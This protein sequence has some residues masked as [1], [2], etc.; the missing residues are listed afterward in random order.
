MKK[1]L[2]LLLALSPFITPA[3]INMGII[4]GEQEFIRRST[5]SCIIV[6]RQDYVMKDTTGGKNQVFGLNGNTYFGR[7]YTLAVLVDTVII[8]DPALFTPWIGDTSY[9][10]YHNMGLIPMLTNLSYRPLYQSQFVTF[11]GVK[12][13]MGAANDSILRKN[14]LTA[15][16][17][18]AFTIKP[19]KSI[20]N[21]SDTSGWL[22]LVYLNENA[23]C[24]TCPFVYNIYKA[25]PQLSQNGKLPKTVQKKNLIGGL[26]F[27]PKYSAAHIE[28]LIAGVLRE[29]LVSWNIKN[30][31]L[32]QNNAGNGGGSV[33]TPV[34]P[35][36]AS[37][38]GEG[39]GEG[40]RPKR[41][42]DKEQ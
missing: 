9:T 20:P 27:I 40:G 22:M 11:T 16:R 21:N 25:R 38:S 4:S 42:K 28:I 8:F 39:S 24:D 37:D 36:D 3:Q 17:N 30:I 5:D 1:I 35:D 2:F 7:A 29:S 15:L 23:G 12:P 26:Y 41:K 6:L 33:L 34:N 10:Q 14:N 31:P 19:I 13:I 18:K 32:L